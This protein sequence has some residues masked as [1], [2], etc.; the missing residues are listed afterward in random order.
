MVVVTAIE[1][2]PLEPQ[3]IR[4]VEG[5]RRHGGKLADIEVLAVNA[6]RG[7]PLRPETKARL[8]R[9]NVQ[10]IYT[11]RPRRYV[12]QHMLHKI[13]CLIEGQEVSKADVV[14]WLDADVLIIGEPTEIMLAPGED[15]AAMP[16]TGLICT[17]GPGNP[18]EAYWARAAQAVGL[19]L[20]SLPWVMAAEDQSRIRFYFNG[21]VFS[22]R[23]ELRLADDLLKDC[24]AILD[25]LAPQ[26][27]IEAHLAEQVG[28]GLTVHK[29]KLRWREIGPACNFS[30]TSREPELFKPELLRDQRILHYHDAMEAHTWELLLSTLK[31][32]HPQVHEWLSKEGPVSDPTRG[33]WKH[34]REAFR[35]W[36]G[37]HRRRYYAK[38]GFRRDS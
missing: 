28:I 22:Y 7:V 30:L 4:M 15:F 14:T 36:R 13:H 5:L 10:T 33:V 34:V 26:R 37:V 19:E 2:G 16:S 21:G 27:H 6:R 35:V 29:R 8:N 9:L 23:R 25:K 24:E 38:A 1:A 18:N 31:Q 3:V 20:E 32:S 12:W 11:R 17:T